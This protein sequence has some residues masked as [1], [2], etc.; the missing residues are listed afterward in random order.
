MSRETIF[1]TFGNSIRDVVTV[2]N[3]TERDQLVADLAAAGEGPATSKALVV[4][5][6]DAPG[7]HQLEYS[8]D[9]TVFVPASGVPKFANDT[10][11]DSWTTSNGGRLSIGDRC[12]SNDVT[13]QWTG[14]VWWFLDQ[15]TLSVVE[16]ASGTAQTITASGVSSTAITGMSATV[17]TPAT[18]RL[19][20][21]Y[22]FQVYAN[23]LNAGVQ[24]DVR[25]GSTDIRS[26]F[27]EAFSTPGTAGNSN[28]ICQTVLLSLA[29]GS[30]ALT[31]RARRIGS[32]GTVT[33][34]HPSGN[35]TF[36]LIETF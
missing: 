30:H 14:S 23:D 33:L 10:A 19:K 28:T 11:R 12:I 8:T 2:A 29:A 16:N 15:H 5:R 25:D 34:P 31:L 1:E 20:V 3:T 6:Q 36:M 35:P 22:S 7:M 9:G 26:T 27:H 4:Y 32:S 17:V 24:I 21:T 13:Y 18:V